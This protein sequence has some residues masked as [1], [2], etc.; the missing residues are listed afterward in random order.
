LRLG[1]GRWAVS[2]GQHLGPVG[3]LPSIVAG[4]RDVRLQVVGVQL[5]LG[6]GHGASE[7]AYIVIGGD[8]ELIL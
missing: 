1:G 5:Q 2:A 4:D 3:R 8:G 7:S 6:E